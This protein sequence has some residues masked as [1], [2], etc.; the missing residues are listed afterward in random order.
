L[1]FGPSSTTFHKYKP[2]Y[3]AKNI[4]VCYERMISTSVANDLR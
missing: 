4:R 1:Q 3:S 2:H